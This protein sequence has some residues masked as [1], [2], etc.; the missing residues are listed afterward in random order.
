MTLFKSLTPDEE[1]PFKQWA[2]ANYIPLDPIPGVW[3]P[4]VQAECVKMNK[5][6]EET[7]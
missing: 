7:S 1:L 5:E 2:R 3:H 4:T 6:L